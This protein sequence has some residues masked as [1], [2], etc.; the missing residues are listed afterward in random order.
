MG[1]RY[2]YGENPPRRHELERVLRKLGWSSHNER[3]PHAVWFSP[4]GKRSTTVCG[5]KGKN[6]PYGTF[7][8]ILKDIGIGE[9]EFLDLA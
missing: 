6:L 4:D 2:A 9:K 3:K 8:A 1:Y 5:H 7:R